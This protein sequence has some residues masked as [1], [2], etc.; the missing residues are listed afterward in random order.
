MDKAHL[1]S[2]IQ[3]FKDAGIDKFA[4]RFEGGNRTVVHG[5]DST[6]IILRENDIIL[7]EPTHNYATPTGQFNITSC[8]YEM[9]DNVR[10]LDVPFKESIEIFK[11]LGIYDDELEA[12]VKSSAKRMA[13][14]P[15]TAGL[16]AIKDSDGKDVIPPGSVG[17]ITQ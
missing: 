17:Y 7:I 12:M 11:N 2:I 14:V 13:I 15:G 4:I 9:I 6:R 16:D 10:A 1:E 8:T 3:A 5:Y